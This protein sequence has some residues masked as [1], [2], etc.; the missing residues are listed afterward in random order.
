LATSV[1][2]PPYAAV[3]RDPWHTLWSIEFYPSEIDKAI[4]AAGGPARAEHFL[5]SVY[6]HEI[7]H[8]VGLADK[9]LAD[10][11]EVLMGYGSASDDKWGLLRTD[12]IT[13]SE[14]AAV[15]RWYGLG[16]P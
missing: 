12:R 6:R 7:G 15:A 5:R 14:K 8:I 2:I 9:A 11:R 10:G 16:L 1:S 13:C 3:F 4:A